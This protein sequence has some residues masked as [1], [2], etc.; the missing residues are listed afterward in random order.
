MINAKEAALLLNCSVCA[1]YHILRSHGII[2]LK[3][4]VQ[5]WPAKSVKRLAEKFNGHKVG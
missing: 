2:I 5:M 4:P 1:V 3:G